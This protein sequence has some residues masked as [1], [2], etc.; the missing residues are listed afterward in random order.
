M[1]HTAPRFSR[2]VQK[3]AL[4]QGE[5]EWDVIVVG[6]G[7]TGLGVG[8]DAAS[9]GYRTLL[10]EQADFAKGTSSRSTKLVH[11]GVRYLAQGNISL[12]YEALYE[13]GLLLQNAPHLVSVQPFVIPSYSWWDKVFYGAGL[14][15][16]DWMAG[17]YRFQKTSLIGKSA[18]ANLLPNVRKKGLKGGIV[19]YDGQ[20]DDARLA[21][22][23]AQTCVEQGGVVL[24]YMKVSGLVKD[25]KG[26]I[27]GVKAHDVETGQ[28]YQLKAK[29]VVNATGVFV[30]DVLQMD[31]PRQQPLVRPSQ[32][33]H[34]VIKR[35]FLK[36][37]NALMLPKTP[38]G[39]VLFA[40]PWHGH[41]LLGTTDTPLENPDLEPTA[42]E[43]EID[44]ILETAGQY[45]E[46]KPT[47]E[48]V[49][50][51]FA[52]LRP[53]AAPTKNS[54]STK[55]IS[56]SHKLIVAPSGLVTITGGKWTTYRK[57]AED[58]VDKAIA[59]AGLPLH[60]C[61]TANL[62]IHGAVNEKNNKLESLSIYG[63]DAGG[64]HELVASN[65]A[66]GKK[67]H[68]NF[69]Y[70]HAEVVWAVRHEMARTV[71][72]VLARR[73]RVLFLDAKAA[74]DMAPQVS[75]LMA[76]EL[77][78]NEEWQQEQVKNFTELA[79]HYLLEPYRHVATAAVDQ[80]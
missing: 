60:P 51:V 20:F 26:K 40:V 63:T 12:V 53:L 67:L 18:V 43:S 8:I 49:L 42:L 48:D 19:Y 74:I 57:M 36:G 23:M 59:V 2:P 4:E 30:N 31:T 11:G 77:G 70:I 37:D 44:F 13:R 27:S 45:L 6:G 64:I 65:S 73:L 50:S 58:T 79:N 9:R 28:E 5:V 3:H 69:S 71:E 14:K 75:A 72:D 62:Q 29:V 47:R 16:Y 32:G 35:S 38:D 24:N 25:Q 61:N 41:V 33:V 15:I 66:L 54:G 52:G 17:R 78:T 7:A 34:V 76:D 80:D 55:E 22:N 21:V 1:K 68:K 56:R 46:D 39:R 10:L